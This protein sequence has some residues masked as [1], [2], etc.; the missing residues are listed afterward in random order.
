MQVI[1]RKKI[2]KPDTCYF[3]ERGIKPHYKDVETLKLFLTPRG[4][5]L[6][7]SKTGVTAKN[8]RLLSVAIKRARELALM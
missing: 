4:K 1:A 8:Q 2:E 7:R 5:V 3:T 6:S